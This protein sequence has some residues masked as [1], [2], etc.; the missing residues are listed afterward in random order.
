MIII[1]LVYHDVDL[2]DRV[3]ARLAACSTHTKKLVN[4]LKFW[5]FPTTNRQFRTNEN[6]SC[7]FLVLHVFVLENMFENAFY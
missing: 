5:I 4:V 7:L 6:I 1:I 3:N 2:L